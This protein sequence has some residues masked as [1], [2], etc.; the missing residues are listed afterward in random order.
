MGIFHLSQVDLQTGETKMRSKFAI[1]VVVLAISVMAWSLSGDKA[2]KK[3]TQAELQKQAR[4]TMDQ[5]KKAALAKENGTI[6][7]SELEKEKGKLIY[8]FDIDVKG[9]IH[10]VNI[11]AVTGALVSDEVES[12]KEEAQEKKTEQQKARKK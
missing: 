8:S 2:R 1:S 4:V 5:A 9:A 11:D 7:E 10:E 6:K 3:E 12:Q